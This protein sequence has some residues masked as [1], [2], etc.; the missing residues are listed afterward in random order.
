MEIIQQVEVYL[1]PI[2]LAFAIL[3]FG[4][5]W[6]YMKYVVE[7]AEHGEEMMI[8]ALASMFWIITL[9]LVVHLVISYV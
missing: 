4:V 3:Y 9:W 1:F 5:G 7:K 8:T 6:A 2:L